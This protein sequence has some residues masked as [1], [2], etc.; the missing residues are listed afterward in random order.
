MLD[1]G[2][3]IVAISTPAGSAGRTIVRASGPDAVAVA[4]AVFRSANEPLTQLGGFRTVPGRVRCLDLTLPARAY[5]F[6]QPR[7][8]TRQDVVELHIPGN[9]IA[10][11]AVMEAMLA[12]GAKP[13]APGQFTQRAFLHGRIDLCQAE[14]V[15]DVIAAAT[16]TQ[17]RAAAGTAGKLRTLCSR[18]SE[19]V[20]EALAETEAGI[21]LS[22]EDIELPSPAVLSDRLTALADDISQVLAES[23]TITGLAETPRVAIAGAPN[24][25]KSSLLNALSGLDRAI[26]SA[27][28][29]TTRDVLTAPMTLPIGREILLADLAGLTP[30]AAGIAHAAN[31]AARAALASSDAVLYVVD[32]ADPDLSL[33]EQI[34]A[35]HDPAVLTLLANKIDLLAGQAPDSALTVLARRSPWPVLGTSAVTAAG[36]TAVKDRLGEVLDLSADRSVSACSLYERQRSAI[37]LAGQA[38]SLAAEQI[39]PLSHIAEQAEI[40]AMELR[41]ALMHLGTIC[42]EVVNEQ[43]LGRIFERFCVGK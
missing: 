32:A 13:A 12:A 19:T 29:G 5:L 27:T 36:L 31:D 6:R 4:A 15:A 2:T 11:S 37:A 1:T 26:I 35:A 40:T 34:A 9:P 43:I 14:A 33:L 41:T 42:G 22:D 18:W 24:V 7:S 16:D 17:L 25:G 3:T 39:R 21:D 28:A 10:A 38:V 23:V 30:H 20:A 8:Y